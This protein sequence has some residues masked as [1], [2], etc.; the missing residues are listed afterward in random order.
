MDFREK[1]SEVTTELTEAE[2]IELSEKVEISSDEVG[3]TGYGDIV[4]VFIKKAKHNDLME[5]EVQ[6]NKTLPKIKSLETLLGQY[7]EDDWVTLEKIYKKYTAEAS[8]E[9][10]KAIT[11]FEKSLAKAFK[12]LEVRTGKL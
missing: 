1:F 12:I 3:I 7:K 8:S 6:G 4:S 10:A 2:T 5:V 11:E 9:V